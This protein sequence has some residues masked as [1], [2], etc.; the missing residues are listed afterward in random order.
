MSA[1]PNNA[2]PGWENSRHLPA[3]PAPE[4]REA[5]GRNA[6][7]GLLAFACVHQQ[8]VRRKRETQSAPAD[9]SPRFSREEELALDEILQLVA[10]RAIAI[11]GADGVAIALAK[12]R[13][14]VCR[15]SA[16]K[17]APD[18]GVRL[19]PDAGFSGACLRG[20]ETVRCD[21]SENDAR[22]NPEACRS[23]GARSMIAVP[24]AARR[25]VIGLLEA[26]SKESHGFND[27]DVRSLNLLAELILAAIR[28]EEEH[29]LAEMA[30]AILPEI[31]APLAPQPT[32]K[33]AA[34]PA[35]EPPPNAAAFPSPVPVTPP[36]VAAPPAIAPAVATATLVSKVLQD[37]KFAPARPSV[38]S[39]VTVSK[40]PAPENIETAKGIVASAPAPTP[41]VA[42]AKT[43]SPNP[44][45]VPFVIPDRAVAHSVDAEVA[46]APL[47]EIEE[48]PREKPSFLSITLTAAAIL[49]VI[50]FGI[51]L[52]CACASGAA[53]E[54]WGAGAG[55]GTSPLLDGGRQHRGC[56]S[57]RP[58]AI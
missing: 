39:G 14:I 32:T 51:A 18:P 1:T 45:T 50:G 15:A 13:A 40:K 5:D 47:F 44:T 22:V 12:D 30:R 9:S 20:G 8:A 29:H 21:D 16:G 52:V 53:V 31:P 38:G 3:A 36:V 17:I 37:E 41:A 25:R 7:Q 35:V 43:I 4:S 42:V 26:F 6:L 2:A 10:A 55:N 56:G 24:L 28:P 57:R 11:T 58:G 27:S 23:L 48:T 19:D 34:L 33:V 46:T 49:V 54:N